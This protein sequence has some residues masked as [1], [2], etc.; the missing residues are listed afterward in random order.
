MKL[1]TYLGTLSCL[2]FLNS[3][4]NVNP[5]H[6]LYNALFYD[7]EKHLQSMDDNLTQLE[8][9]EKILEKENQHLTLAVINKEKK[10]A[11]VEKH[12]HQLSMEIDD[13]HG[14]LNKITYDQ[15]LHKIKEVVLQIKEEINTQ[16]LFQKYQLKQKNKVNQ[17]IEYL[18]D[19]IE[20]G[21]KENIIKFVEQ[22]ID[23]GRIYL[24]YK[25]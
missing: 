24:Q 4:Q 1:S 12:F 10:I 20:D 16:E 18:L 7:Y 6:G 21:E 19:E 25:K 2:I 9:S 11:D 17:N 23:E 22:T 3:C 5:H 14:S 13:I 15:K 8:E